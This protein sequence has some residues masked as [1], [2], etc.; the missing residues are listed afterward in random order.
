MKYNNAMGK[1]LVVGSIAYDHIMTYDGL[2]QQVLLPEKLE[3]L[4]VTFATS[5]KE[6]HYGGCGGNIAYTLRLFAA[7][8]FLFG[9]AGKDFQ[10]YQD[11]LKKN[12]IDTSGIALD[13]NLFTASAYILTDQ[14]HRQI[15]IFHMGAMGADGHHLSLRDLNHE[16]M[17]WAIIAPDHPERMIRIAQECSEFKI[18]FI[19]DP[20][21]QIGAMTPAQLKIGIEMAT[22]LI[23]ND[24]EAALLAKK[25]GIP[26]EKL[27]SLV[28]NYIETH[29]VDGSSG[30][31]PEGS[32]FVR[33]VKPAV[34]ADPTGCGDAY[35]AGVLAGLVGGLPLEKCCQMGALAATYNL[36]KQGTQG[37][38]FT[39]AEFDQRLKEY[40]G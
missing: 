40:F 11:W 38:T 10:E 31:T 5:T 23:V 12:D 2:F 17:S 26:K 36:E 25:L 8:P 20:A 35:R 27:P 39:R 28:P 3:S 9:V 6:I 22:V 29:G 4:S 16:E 30:S 34:L 24:Y 19:F 32:F 18:P 21:Q 1:I 14:A 33:S 15:T 13:K 37:H 7:N